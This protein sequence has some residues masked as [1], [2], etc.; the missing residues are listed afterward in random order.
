M[1]CI[2]KRGLTEVKVF[3]TT[4]ESTTW[5]S[6]PLPSTS[7]LPDCA[8]VAIQDKLA[9]VGG[10]SLREPS[11]F[12]E[13]FRARQRRAEPHNQSTWDCTSS[14]TQDWEQSCSQIDGDTVTNCLATT[15]QNWLILVG[16]RI[17]GDNHALLKLKNCD[18]D[19]EEQYTKSITSLMLQGNVRSCLA[20]DMWFIL[21]ETEGSSNNNNIYSISLPALIQCVTTSN[22]DISSMW[23]TQQLPHPQSAPV[24]I[25]DTLFLIGGAVCGTARGYRRRRPVY[26]S[27]PTIFCFQPETNELV[28]AGYLPFPVRKCICTMTTNGK[29]VMIGG[30]NSEQS[31][32]NGEI[33][34]TI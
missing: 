30:E 16:C 3:D 33:F 17:T 8:M 22:T 18:T 12:A 13:R 27:L 29:I 32:L 1:K 23:K 10:R 20:G 24:C 19:T 31:F 21:S 34:P 26:T 2:T 5:Q 25:R 9:L 15:Y 11:S 6:L 4:S 28:K 7:I 14:D